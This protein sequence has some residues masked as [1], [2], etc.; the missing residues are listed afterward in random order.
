[1]PEPS[2]R[3]FRSGTLRI[4]VRIWGDP[5]APPLIIVH[6]LRDHSHSFDDL[7][8]G[9]LDRFHVYALDLRGHGDSE[10]TPYYAFGHFV[11]DLHNCIRAAHR[12]AG[13]GGALDGREIVVCGI[14]PAR[15]VMSRAQPPRSV[16]RRRWLIDI[17][18]VRSPAPARTSTR[19]LRLRERN[20]GCARTGDGWRGSAR[21]REGGCAVKF[22][23]CSARWPH[24]AVQPRVRPGLLAPHRGPTLIVHGAESGEFWR[25]KRNAI[26][27]EPDDLARRLAC[28]RDHRFL[29]I[30][31]AGHMVHFDRP[32]EL[33]TAIRDFLP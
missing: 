10:T 12:A 21:A 3:F 23:P 19:L 15:I 16:W 7:A 22:T 24:R 5:A 31:G 11:L 4:H 20:P 8:R 28:F 2:E 26:Y 6:G 14:V 13:P 27:L 32:R 30:A 29:E 17:C 9:L 33:V 18:I 1:M 25:R